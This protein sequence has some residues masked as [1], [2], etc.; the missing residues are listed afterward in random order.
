[1]IIPRRHIHILDVIAVLLFS[2]LANY[3][4]PINIEF[5]APVDWPTLIKLILLSLSSITF[6]LTVDRIKRIATYSSEEYAAETSLS[7]R[8]SNSVDARY[9]K[10]YA[11]Q[12]HSLNSA[13]FISV[14]LSILFFLID[15][16]FKLLK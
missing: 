3:V 11:A 14:G 10:Y 12:K 1:M 16:L 13:I 2:L 7:T 5:G 4:L 9:T 6:Y 8:A 15:P